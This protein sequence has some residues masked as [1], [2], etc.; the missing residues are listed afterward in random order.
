M[1]DNVVI[2]LIGTIGLFITTTPALLIAL[3]NRRHLIDAK[4]HAQ[5]AASKADV[6]ATTLGTINGNGDLMNMMSRILEW[7]A[8]HLAD[9]ME[10]LKLI[11]LRLS[12]VENLLDARTPKFDLLQREFEELSAYMHTRNHEILN[13]LT[14]AKGKIDML[15]GDSRFNT[16]ATNDE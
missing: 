9:D 13:A 5:I 8:T 10:Q 14:G 11:K 7:Q 2:A 15:W 16:E 1:S 6:V 3:S 12:A 4:A